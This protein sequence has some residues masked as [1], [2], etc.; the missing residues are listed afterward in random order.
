[1]GWRRRNTETFT[2]LYTKCKTFQTFRILKYPNVVKAQQANNTN[3]SH[4]P[5]PSNLCFLPM[6]L[7]PLYPQ[8]CP[9]KYN[10]PRKTNKIPNTV[11]IVLFCPSSTHEC[12]SL[13][14]K[15]T[16]SH[17]CFVGPVCHYDY[18]QARA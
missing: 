4:K 7:Y 17:P 8:N 13:V 15:Y 1:M 16:V 3:K 10:F 12:L 14:L 9:Y 5:I 2:A 6:S 11:P 18:V